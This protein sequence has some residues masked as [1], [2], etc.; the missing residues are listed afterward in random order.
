MLCGSL[1]ATHGH[2]AVRRGGGGRS[3]VDGR[4]TQT[5]QETGDF[6]RDPPNRAAADRAHGSLRW[7]LVVPREIDGPKAPES[8]RES[9]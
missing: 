4:G 8:Q 3:M 7:C 5:S 1:H 9:M 6:D 2:D